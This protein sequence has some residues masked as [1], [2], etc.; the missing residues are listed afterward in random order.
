MNYRQALVQIRFNSVRQHMHQYPGD[1][2]VED[3]V[4]VLFSAYVLV[5]STRNNP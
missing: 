3:F 5:G 1:G 2:H 4:Q